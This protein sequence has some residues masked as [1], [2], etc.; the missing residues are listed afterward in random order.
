MAQRAKPVQPDKPGKQNGPHWVDVDV[1]I[2]L[3]N[4][5]KAAEMSQ[6][7]LGAECGISF[8]Q[9][10]KYEKGTNRISVSM[11]WQLSRAL[12]VP[13]SKLLPPPIKPKVAELGAVRPTNYREAA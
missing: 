13:M 2:R 4:F 12:H 8:Q 6:E 7:R 5:R 1:G 10:Q 9:I 3:R 11:L